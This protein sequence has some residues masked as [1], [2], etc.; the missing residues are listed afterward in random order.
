MGS[1]VKVTVKVKGNGKPPAW[2]RSEEEIVQISVALT[3]LAFRAVLR[4]G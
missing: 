4:K 1:K 2:A 3:S